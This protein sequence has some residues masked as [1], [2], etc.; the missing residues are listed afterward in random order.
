MRVRVFVLAGLATVMA[1]SAIVIAQEGS[2]GAGPVAASGEWRWYSGDLGSSKYSA[3]DQINKDNVSQLKIAWRRSGVDESIKQRK[4][5]LS[6]PRDFRATPLMINGMLYSPNGIGLVEAFHAGTGKTVW[7]QQPFP[8]EA[9]QGL[10]GDSTRSV[11]YWSD[12][13]A[14]R[15]FVIRGEYMIALD[16]D[17]GRPVADWGDGGR[18]NLKV[19]LGPRAT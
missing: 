15:L 17:T 4:A 5:D 19:G 3:L 2:R 16:A 8:D 6:V 10:S 18:L 9:E 14:Q 12:G 7:V 13:S 11:A 1:A